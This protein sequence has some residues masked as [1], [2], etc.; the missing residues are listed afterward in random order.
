MQ[1]EC[2]PKSGWCHKSTLEQVKG[3]REKGEEYESTRSPTAAVMHASQRSQR[4]RRQALPPTSRNSMTITSDRPYSS[5]CSEASLTCRSK[6][7][8]TTSSSTPRVPALP[9][10]PP[11]PPPPPAPPPAPSPAPPSRF[12]ILPMCSAAAWHTGGSSA[13]ATATHN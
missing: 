13:V 5:T 11:P 2:K 1:A 7:S 4:H 12:R 9:P 3:E 10:S 8:A 6:T